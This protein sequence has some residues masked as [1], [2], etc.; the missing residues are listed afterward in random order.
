MRRDP[1]YDLLFEEVSIGPV[2]ARNRFYQVPH[3]NGMGHRDP[4]A[5]A[6]MRRVKAEGGWAVVSTEEVE[7]HPSSET[8]P[9]IEGRLWDDADIPAHRLVTDAVHAH[10]ALAAIELVHSG[11]SQPNYAARLPP[12]GPGH[13][14]LAGNHYVPIQ[15]RR[16]GK[17]DIADLR[18]WHRRAAERAIEAGYDIVYVYAGHTLTTLQFFLSPHFNQRTDEYGGSPENRARLLREVLEDTR[19]AAEGKAAV[20]CRLAVREPIPDGLDRPQIEELLGLVGELPD[21]WDFIVGDWA[22]DSTPSRFGPEGGHEEHVRGLKEL[23][24]KPVVGVGRFTSPDTMVSMVRR[25]ILDFIGAA[26]PSI[27]DPFLP[28]KISEGRIDEI[29]ECIGCNMCV[30]GDYTSS[31]IRCTQNP[32]MG[33]EWRRGWHPEAFRSVATTERVMVVGAGPAGLEAAMA[34]GKRGYDVVLIEAA[35]GLGGRVARESALPGLAAWSRVMDY[36]LGQIQRLP[37]VEIY[38]ESSM[39]STE[40]L[41]HGFDHLAIATGATWRADGVGH[42]HAVPI[43][44]DPATEL[45]TPDDLLSGHRPSGPRVVLFDDD[46]YYLGGVLAELLAREDHFVTLVTPAPDVSHWTHHTLEQHRI[47]AGLLRVGVS[48]VTGSALQRVGAAHVVASSVYTGEEMTLEADAVVLVTSRLPNEDLALEFW[49]RRSAWDDA[50]L[51]TMR[52]VGDAFA[53]GTIA[54]AVWDGRRFAE[55][56]DRDDEPDLYR[57]NVPAVHR[58]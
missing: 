58:D 11:M 33:E 2:V 28:A 38:R 8:T 21:L 30:S 51:R 22:T 10:G 54:A 7:I 48:I 49:D 27:A 6:E 29:R 13:R 47:Q 9:Y 46:H 1:R 25:G 4:N 18:R 55:T 56:L 37:N 43:A 53:P 57:R 19:E 32:S 24:S 39:T 50:G 14:V 20:A 16:M 40:I 52:A 42:T 41:E 26:R 36:R 35:R 3:C 5:L 44:V 23:T 12:M 17:R 31:P 34:A 45:F 15:A